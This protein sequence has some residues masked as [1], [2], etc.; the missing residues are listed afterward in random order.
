VSQFVLSLG[1]FSIEQGIEEKHT[2]G[3]VWE[4]SLPF[5]VGKVAPFDIGGLYDDTA[6]SGPDLL[7]RITTPDT[8]ATGSRTLKVT[9]KTTGGTKSTSVECFRTSYKVS[10]DRNGLT[11]F[12]ATVQPTGATT[13]V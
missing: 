10:A 3:D 13:E 11:K 1:D 4:E 6:V 9:W 8:A 2:F 5:G 12:S 7:F